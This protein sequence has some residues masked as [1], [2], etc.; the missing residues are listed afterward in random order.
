MRLIL[1]G[2][3]NLDTERTLPG[4]DVQRILR[5]KLDVI[6]VSTVRKFIQALPLPF[7]KLIY[8]LCSV[9]PIVIA[10]CILNLRQV[11]STTPDISALCRDL[12]SD[13]MSGS[14]QFNRQTD[15]ETRSTRPYTDLNVEDE[16]VDAEEA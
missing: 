7:S 12:A 10:R 15:L 4:L 6:L 8:S 3:R 11:S 5:T 16:R 13:E 9:T 14:V 2:L 1:L